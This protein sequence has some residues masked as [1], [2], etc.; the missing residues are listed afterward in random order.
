MYDSVN[1][2]ARPQKK[3]ERAYLPGA[4]K[5]PNQPILQ[6]KNVDETSEQARSFSDP[7]SAPAEVEALPV[8]AHERE[9]LISSTVK[10]LSDVLALVRPELFEKAGKVQR[11]AHRLAQHMPIERLCELDLAAMLYPI[12]LLGLPDWLV[13][14]YVVGQPLSDVEQRKVDES[15]EV[16]YQLVCNIPQLECV[17]RVLYYS[18]AGY[19]G[20]GF[21]S[22]EL[23]GAK[24]PQS[25]RILRLLIDFV[26]LAT[27]PG[28]TR[29]DAFRQMVAK[30][31]VYDPDIL[32]QAGLVFVK[33]R[34]E[35]K[36]DYERILLKPQQLVPGDVV[37]SDIVDRDDHLL[38]AAGAELTPVSIRRLG[39]YFMNRRFDG[40]VAV[41]RRIAVAKGKGVA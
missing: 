29:S 33:T 5:T 24:I 3:T 32:K 1:L 36:R 26:D 11:W 27:G 20:S 4:L 25:A 23:T 9:I 7:R 8:A 39:S 40:N 22:G 16:A 38:L 21:P 15:A 2:P 31:H 13:N 12:G 6:P 34:R 10:L 18:R 17:A 30:R 28:R 19:D 41:Q 35:E 14:K 37:A